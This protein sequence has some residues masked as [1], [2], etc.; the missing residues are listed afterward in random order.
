M[1]III[2]NSA[3]TA[4]HE[5]MV[6]KTSDPSGGHLRLFPGT[7]QVVLSSI[8]LR[9]SLYQMYKSTD[10]GDS[11]NALSPDFP[12]FI[13]G[14]NSVSFNNRY[15]Y[16]GDPSTIDGY[17]WLA[18]SNDF[19]STFTYDVSNAVSNSR[20]N[21]VV[22]SRDGK[23]VI[24]TSGLYNITGDMVFSNDFGETWTHPLGPQKW[25]NPFISPDG[26]NMIVA[27]DS[28]NSPKV[29]P[30]YSNDYGQSW[31]NFPVNVSTLAGTMISGDGNYKVVWESFENTA[32]SN[33]SA[34]VFISQ[35]WI[36]WD[37][38]SFLTERCSGGAI[39]NDGKYML[40]AASDGYNV[41]DSA[42][43]LS[44]DYGQ[45]WQKKSLGVTEYWFDCAMSSDG[46][47]MIVVPGITT[48]SENYPRK[49]ID[50]GETWTEVTDM[51]NARY[52][53]VKMSKSGRYVYAYAINEGVIHSTDY[54]AT[55]TQQFDGSTGAS[56]FIN[57]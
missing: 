9:G 42:I 21:F 8:G 11:Y 43:N 17:Y 40:I 44:T 6:I 32:L 56:T 27:G 52:Y 28:W 31:D 46:K 33:P 48:G 20:F 29:V 57:F 35:N 39:S 4:G 13:A 15:Y 34:K 30:Q 10:S 22:S 49:S 25:Y 41:A 5:R 14:N 1:G 2:K 18:R 38:S 3:G 53:G 16:V 7:N 50:Y 23:Y 47:Y 36:N 19:G 37:V 12:A 54:M 55:W 26:Q 51:P 24:A 45:T